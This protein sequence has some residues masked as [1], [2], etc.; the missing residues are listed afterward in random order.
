M[1]QEHSDDELRGL[2]MGAP[3]TTTGALYAIPAASGWFPALI[4]TQA[5]FA[6]VVHGMI[7]EAGAVDLAAL[8]ADVGQERVV[9]A[10]EFVRGLARGQLVADRAEQPQ[11]DVPDRGDGTAVGPEVAVLGPV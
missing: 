9:A 1:S 6:T 2:G 3:A 10:I 11:R 5:R 8:Q 7:H 4:P